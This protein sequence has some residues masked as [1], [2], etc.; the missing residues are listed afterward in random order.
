MVLKESETSE[1]PFGLP[2]SRAWVPSIRSMGGCQ[3]ASQ[4]PSQT[5]SWG[6]C[7]VLHLPAS[8]PQQRSH[9]PAPTQQDEGSPGV[10][11]QWW[12]GAPRCSSI[13]PAHPGCPTAGGM[14][15]RCG[16]KSSNNPWLLV[17]RA[18]VVQVVQWKHSGF[19]YFGGG[20][21]EA[22]WGL[23]KKKSVSFRRKKKHFALFPCKY[24][25]LVPQFSSGKP[26]L[27]PT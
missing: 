5:F 27:F 20:V 8:P 23:K 4:T 22:L 7:P 16:A 12:A 17:Q 21:G 6:S 1:S 10:M 3:D 24:L 19:S 14:A 11:K 26:M 15:R 18:A 9:R 2:L 13:N 25:S